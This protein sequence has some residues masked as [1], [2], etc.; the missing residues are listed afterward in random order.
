MIMSRRE[1]FFVMSYNIINHSIH[2]VHTAYAFIEFMQTNFIYTTTSFIAFMLI[3]IHPVHRHTH[4][5]AYI[6]SG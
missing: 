6:S 3:Y 5:T 1:E 4:K 2:S